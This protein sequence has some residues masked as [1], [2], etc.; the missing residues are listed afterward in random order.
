MGV[1]DPR[2]IT[3]ENGALYYQREGRPKMK[4]IPV[5]EDTFMFEEID[6]FHLQIITKDGKAVGVKGLYDSGR[7]DEHKKS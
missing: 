4:M 2:K 1:Y 3:F 7:S 6:Y 5:N